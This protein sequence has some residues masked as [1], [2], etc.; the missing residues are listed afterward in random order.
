MPREPRERDQLS[1][2]RGQGLSVPEAVYYA[3]LFILSGFVV[4]VTAH[5][6]IWRHSGDGAPHPSIPAIVDK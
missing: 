4:L 1:G 3:L 5:L 6:L 2:T